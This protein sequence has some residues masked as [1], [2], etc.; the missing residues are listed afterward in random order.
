MKENTHPNFSE[1]LDEMKTRE[2][3]DIKVFIVEDDQMIRELVITKLI[4]KGCIP[5]A[6][7]DGSKAIVLAEQYKP[8]VIILDLMLPGMTG[9]E[10]LSILKSSGTLRDIPVMVFSNKS[11]EI[12][13]QKV[14][15][16]GADSYHV[17]AMTDL[18]EFVA[19]LKKL[20]HKR[21]V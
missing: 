2:L 18:N 8:D 20:A 4:Q 11:E 13:R 21:S 3:G 16:L 5:Y 1:V 12:D 14:L 17:K 15:A 19:E 6:T 7:G 9:E 10:V